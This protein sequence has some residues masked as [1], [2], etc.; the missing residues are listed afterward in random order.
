MGTP[1]S[2]I[3]QIQ[4][5][6]FLENELALYDLFNDEDDRVEAVEHVYRDELA[7]LTNAQRE[8]FIE[9]I[10]D[11][12]DNNSRINDIDDKIEELREEGE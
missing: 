2:I 7:T 8:E 6:Q 4:Q 12:F 10:K 11:E 3:A 5:A 9:F 1:D